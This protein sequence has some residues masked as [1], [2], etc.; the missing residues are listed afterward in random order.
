M[1]ERERERERGREK[2][3]LLFLL[4]IYGE[5]IC[6]CLARRSTTAETKITGQVSASQP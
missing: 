5:L 3:L 4:G 6:T 1:R 2:E